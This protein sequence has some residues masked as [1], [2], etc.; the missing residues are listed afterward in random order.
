[1]GWSSRCYILSFEEIGPP[2]LE[3]KILKGFYRKG[4]G[5]H[6]GGMAWRS[7]DQDIANESQCNH[8]VNMSM[9][10]YRDF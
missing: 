4:H 5:G 2:V 3:K 7:C 1:M 10:I 8:Y 9:Q 6:H